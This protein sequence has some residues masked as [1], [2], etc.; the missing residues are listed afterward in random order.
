M[1]RSQSQ[2]ATQD[3]PSL[4]QT[5]PPSPHLKSLSKHDSVSNEKDE[6]LQPTPPSTGG[7]EEKPPASPDKSTILTGKKLALVFIALSVS[8]VPS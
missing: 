8:T 3:R 1:S 2:F 6:H 5:L 7:A 4:E